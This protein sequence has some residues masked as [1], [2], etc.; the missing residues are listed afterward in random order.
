MHAALEDTEDTYTL[1]LPVAPTW[2][3]DPGCYGRGVPAHW[4]GP[5]PQ[6][7]AK[8]P[9]SSTLELEGGWQRG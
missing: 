6:L 5:P 9:T 7:K 1:L 3:A 4:Q 2:G 8:S